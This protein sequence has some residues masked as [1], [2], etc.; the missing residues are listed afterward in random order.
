MAKI[1]EEKVALAVVHSKVA[2]EMM[3]AD[4]TIRHSLVISDIIPEDLAVVVGRDEFVKWLEGGIIQENGKTGRKR[5]HK[6]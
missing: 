1:P 4:P 2:F 3:K 6:S 5:R